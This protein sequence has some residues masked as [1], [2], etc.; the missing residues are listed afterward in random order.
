M[1]RSNISKSAVTNIYWFSVICSI[2]LKSF[3]IFFFIFSFSLFS[4][5]HYMIRSLNPFLLKLTSPYWYRCCFFHTVQGP[6]CFLNSQLYSQVELLCWLTSAHTKIAP[7]FKHIVSES[8]II[9]Q[10]SE[11]GSPGK[12]APLESFQNDRLVFLFSGEYLRWRLLWQLCTVQ[13]MLPVKCISQTDRI[14]Y[15]QPQC[16]QYF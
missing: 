5:V 8:P 16:L 4:C 3:H 9:V 6:P 12:H 15:L 2:T 13:Q 11:D 7:L 1:I 14:Y 10:Q